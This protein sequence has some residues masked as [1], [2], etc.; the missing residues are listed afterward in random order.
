MKMLLSEQD[1]AFLDELQVQ[2]MLFDL[3]IDWDSLTLE[4]ARPS[5]VPAWAQ[6]YRDLRGQADFDERMDI[7]R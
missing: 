5:T 1:R 3:E 4:P 2:A 7:D 6:K